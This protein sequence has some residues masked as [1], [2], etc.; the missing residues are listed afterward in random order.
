MEK[1]KTASTKVLNTFKVQPFI[2]RT[3]Y[4]TRN[5]GI[6]LAKLLKPGDM[7]FLYGEVG[8]GKTIFCQG[9]LR[10]FNKK[11]FVR[12]SS[13][14]LVNE[15]QLN[16]LKLFHID[17]YRLNSSNLW[18]I[19]I[20]EYLYSGENIA[21]VE[22]ADKLMDSQDDNVWSIKFEILDAKRK[23]IIEKKNENSIS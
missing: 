4:Q 18:D 7:V 13:F 22:W 8:S 14:M 6:Q 3:P 2:S 10:G 9:V 19:G 17:L 20:E 1:N 5:L 23:I 15:Y 21:L 12:S 16:G 11:D